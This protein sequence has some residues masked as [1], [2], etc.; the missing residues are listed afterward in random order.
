MADRKPAETPV[1]S[2][3]ASQPAGFRKFP[4]FG[5]PRGQP[6]FGSGSHLAARD[7]QEFA[8]AT[9]PET[10][11]D[12]IDPQEPPGVSPPQPSPS[13]PRPPEAEP[14]PP[15]IDEPDRCPEETPYPPA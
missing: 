14:L 10:K 9:V 4:D 5:S 2:G 6:G 3:A 15:D 12:R 7:I 11:P 1:I 8:M 13:T